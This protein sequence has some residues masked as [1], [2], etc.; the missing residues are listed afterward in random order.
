MLSEKQ[1]APVVCIKRRPGVVSRM[2][3]RP[4]GARAGRASARVEVQ[5]KLDALPE[6]RVVDNGQACVVEVEEASL[7]FRI[8][9]KIK[10]WRKAVDAFNAAEVPM[11][12]FKG[13]RVIRADRG[14]VEL[15]GVGPQVIDRAARKGA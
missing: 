15:E 12:I 6:A 4:M 10:T 13:G 2:P 1:P 5:L 7:T 9:L 14:V 8:R 11:L 3:P